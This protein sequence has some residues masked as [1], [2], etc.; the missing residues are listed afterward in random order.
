MI[1][2]AIFGILILGFFLLGCCSLASGPT[3]DRAQIEEAMLQ[4]VTSYPCANTTL[5]VATRRDAD[6]GADAKWT[7]WA[8]QDTGE[9]YKTHI[10]WKV[11]G[12][13]KEYIFLYDNQTKLVGSYN[14][15]ARLILDLCSLGK[16]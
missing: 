9:I 3:S 10:I 14:K 12:E 13:Q 5:L 1:K 15:E 8:I 11:G 4:N 2:Y 16:N 7:G 6:L